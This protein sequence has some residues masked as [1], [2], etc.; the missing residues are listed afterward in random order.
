MG[1]KQLAI[2]AAVA[3]AGCLPRAPPPDLSLDP[4]E[5]L[6]QVR[7]REG[8]TRS[9]RGEA[10][11]RLRGEAASGSVP[12]WIAAE[13]PDRIYVQTLD[14]FG[15]TLAVLAA[16]DGEL[17]LYDARERVLYRGAATAEN[18]R[19]LV[20]L[21][22]SPAALAEIL[23][24]SAPL[25]DGEPVRAEPGRGS[26]TLELV[27]GARTQELR[28][29]PSA[30]VERSALLVG[31]GKGPGAYDLEFASFGG[32]GVPGFPARISLAAE[33]PPVRMELTWSDI[34]TD[35]AIDVALFHPP[36]PRGARV[37]ELAETPSPAGLIP[38]PPPR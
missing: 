3:L 15:N 37:E 20:P 35:A 26:V 11:L 2:A 4:A 8:N 12:A 28:V 29:G 13:K 9:V 18:L 25:I 22:I 36:V 33:S 27:G 6:R 30:R 23:C 34:E 21:P 31:G 7:A 1:T 38:D 32:A 17:S 5:L 14:F 24:G 19:R 16:A 10:R